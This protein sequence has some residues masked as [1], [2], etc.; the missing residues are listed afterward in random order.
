MKDPFLSTLRWA[1]RSA[2]ILQ[3]GYFAG[4]GFM[5][6]INNCTPRNLIAFLEIHRTFVICLHVSII[7]SECRHSGLLKLHRCCGRTSSSRKTERHS[8]SYMCWGCVYANE[9]TCRDLMGRQSQ[10]PG[11][12]YLLSVWPFSWLLDNA[13]T[14]LFGGEAVHMAAT[15]EVNS[16]SE[17]CLCFA[18]LF[19]FTLT[20]CWYVILEMFEIILKCFFLATDN[21]ALCWICIPVWLMYV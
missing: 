14:C 10:T 20:A 17:V 6:E 19:D 16:D 15:S 4:S 12:V 1:G 8:C 18:R 11:H 7:C 21:K 9:T 5:C 13:F 3:W 2:K